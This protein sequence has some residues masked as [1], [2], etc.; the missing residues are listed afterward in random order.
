MDK[1]YFSY[2]R[3]STVRQGQTG[4]SLVEQR[5]A[6]RLYAERAS[7]T[8]VK[9]FEEQETAAK[10][11]R[12]IFA[13]MLKQIKDAKADG[14]IIHKI[15]RSARNLKDWADL[16]EIIDSGVE[17]RF[18]NESLDLHSR[19]GRLSAD[20]QAVVAADYI[21]NL[22]EE[23][24]KGFYG[25][26]KQGLYPMPA[27]IGYLDQGKGLP[28]T[29]DPVNAPL[30]AEA[31]ELY[32]SGLWGLNALVDE[33]Y[34][35]GLRNKRG[36]QVTRNGLATMLHNPF[37]MG[38]IRLKT[39][40]E[41]FVGR[42]EPLITKA[43]FDHVQLMLS[44]KNVEKHHRHEF[45]FRKHVRCSF[46]DST[47]I[48]ETQKGHIYYR[49]HAKGCAQKSL[50]EEHI[51]RAFTTTLKQL[52]FNEVEDGYLQS[53]IN[54]MDGLTSDFKEAQQKNLQLQHEQIKERLSKLTDAFLNGVFDQAAYIEKKNSLLLEEQS[55]KE[56]LI[57]LD[58]EDVTLQKVKSFLELVN[59]AYLSY[60]SGIFGERREMVKTIT[61]N[62]TVAYQT[63]LVKL[64]YPFQIVVERQ[65]VT[66]GSPRSDVP[67][68]LSVLLS[69]LVDYFRENE[70]ST[71]NSS[72]Y[73]DQIIY[74][75]DQVPTPTDRCHNSN[76]N[77]PSPT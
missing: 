14:I 62:F 50:R 53:E 44:G 37:Y 10:R 66:C 51:E 71:P 60:Q 47:L 36:K 77:V 18:V 65:K 54:Q 7:L 25:R 33:M 31:F 58:Q 30:V 38:L 75:N 24:K 49:C 28:K 34:R 72:L 57:K 40:G 69:Q 9:E 17:V 39:T 68:A 63:V 67:R 1:R 41:M 8:I 16:G 46:S 27:R 15:D 70:L 11:G 42:H 22:R 48:G 26:I 52:Q 55:V 29:P 74:S 21:R 59:N 76:A 20:I 4:T 23:T 45:L 13:Q 35:R 2:I 61:S 32:A 64:N 73:L 6:I 56:N 19:G 43:I 5:E 3:V 12:P